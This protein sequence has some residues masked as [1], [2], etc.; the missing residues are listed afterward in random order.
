MEKK[1]LKGLTALSMAS[2]VT[3]AA[4]GTDN[5]SEDAGAA[6]VNDAGNTDTAEN[7][8][9]D[10]EDVTL[11]FMHLWPQG[12]SPDHYRIVSQIIEEFEDMH[13]HVTVE[14]EVLENEQYKNKMQVISSSNQLP[15]VGMTWPAG[16]MEPYVNGNMFAPLDD[17][18]DEDGLRDD[19]V[20]GTLEA[21][22]MNGDSYA[23]PL[24]LNI[25]PVFY[26][27]AIFDEYGVDVPETFDDFMDAID[28]F[29]EN[30]MA[31]IALGNRD[32]WTGSLWYMYLADRIGGPDALN[33]AIDRSG[34]FEDERLIEAAERTVDMVQSD[35]FIRGFNGL[36]DQ[37]AKSEFMN[38]NAAMY[39]IGSWDL[40]NYTTNEEVPQE[41]RD[42][43][44]FFKFPE[45]DGGDGDINSWV[46]GP[47]VGLFVAENSDIQEEAKAFVKYFAEEW[48]KY[49]VEDAGVIPGT[50]VDTDAVDLPDLFVE[51]LDELNNASNITLFADVQ[52]SAG[53][54]ET[55]LNQIQALF[56][57]AVTPEDF[58]REHEEA[59]SDED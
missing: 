8:D 9:A 16:Y 50:Q 38:S 56:G 53:V 17:I 24:E 5:T 37:E 44:G 2:L 12:S 48:G 27:K 13:P 35:A 57:E 28:T 41:F 15:D 59:L 51:V 3:L 6:G 25:A 23:L 22:E 30:D 20:A 7:G 33:A 55:H 10:K 52:M 40:P 29:V 49:S 31:P 46:G 34:S 36:S 32:R 11:D 21:Y 14:L 4:C 47:G 1:A 39:L 58:A 42:N 43:I 19:F 18:L 54:A 26:N 45:V